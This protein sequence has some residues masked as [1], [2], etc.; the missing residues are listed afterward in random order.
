MGFKHT[1]IFPEQAINWDWMS[2]KIRSANR[3]VRVLNLFA[4]TGGASVA[5]AKA[6]A[7]VCHVD[8][9]KGIVAKA[10]R[11]AELSGIPQNKI[12]VGVETFVCA[13]FG[14]AEKFKSAVLF[15]FFQDPY[16]DSSG[17]GLSYTVERLKGENIY[18]HVTLRKSERSELAALAAKK[19]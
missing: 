5:A 10:K 2:E 1:G 6:G 7:F 19:L 14:D 9:S 17:N 16:L 11:N 3:P 15:V 12:D 13:G 4:Y 8:A 18:G